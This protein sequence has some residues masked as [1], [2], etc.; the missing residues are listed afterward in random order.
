LQNELVEFLSVDE[1]IAIYDR[2]IERFGGTSGI[3]DKG[4]LESALFRP[5]TG[6]YKDI[7]E[8][9]AALFESLILNH[10]FVD[11]NK[12]AAFFITDT[13]LRLNGWKLSVETDSAHAFIVGSLERRECSFDRLLPWIR[14]SL[15]RI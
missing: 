3:R 14:D 11:G 2:L 6:Y 15:V 9:A 7:A 5:Q 4:L 8:L 10:A 1:A 13:F 12:R